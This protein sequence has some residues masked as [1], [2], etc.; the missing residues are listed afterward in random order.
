ESQD[1]GSKNKGGDLGWVKRGQMVKKFEDAL[2]ALKKGETSDPVETEF[3]WHLIKVEDV[4]E[5]R[6][7]P[8]ED[9]E[10]QAELLKA[11]RAKDAQR[12]FQE[13]S[14]KL[15][16]TAFE[17]PNSLDGAAKAVGLTVQ[18]SDW[19]TRTAGAGIADKPAVREAAFADEVLK[20][21]EH[22]KPVP[23]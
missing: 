11:Y 18:T 20:S 1:P 22:S 7:K 16:Q 14:E 9:A 13:M 8:F 2:F 3:G 15:E 17:S 21:G 23:T 10:V 19:F 4:R 6:T 5:G 12:R